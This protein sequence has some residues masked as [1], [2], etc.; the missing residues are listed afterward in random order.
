MRH[1]V[2]SD[3]FPSHLFLS[4]SFAYLVLTFTAPV[5]VTSFTAGRFL[6]AFV[7]VKKKRRGKKEKTSEEGEKGIEGGM[8]EGEEEEE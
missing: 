4:F 1:K 7:C 2:A 6:I 3:C 5:R 8:G